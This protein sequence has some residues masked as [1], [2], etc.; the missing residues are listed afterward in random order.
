MYK[1]GQ[2]ESRIAFHPGHRFFVMLLTAT[3]VLAIW[4]PAAAGLF[5]DPTS[6]KPNTNKPKAPLPPLD[7]KPLMPSDT[8]DTPSTRSS[9]PKSQPK[10]KPVE[11]AKLPIPT[12]SAR[13]AAEKQVKD[14]MGDEIAKARTP[15]DK[16]KLAVQMLQTADGT[17][18]AASKY[19]LLRDG[20]GL[21]ADAGDVETAMAA[22]SA[23][24]RDFEPDYSSGAVDPLD[25]FSRSSVDAQGQGKLCELALRGLGNAIAANRFD[26]ARQFG[27]LAVG[28]AHKSNDRNLSDRAGSMMA[29]ITACESEYARVAPFEATLKKTP[30]D[31]SAN[32]A[33]GRF[34]CFVKGNWAVGL[35]ML[36]K[37]SNETLK[38]AAV[39]E[40][41]PPATSQEQL[42][43]ADA[44]WGMTDGLPAAIQ[45]TVRTHAAQWYSQASDGLSGLPK[46]KAEQ[47]VAQMQPNASKPE[48][49]TAQNPKSSKP[50]KP[51]KPAPADDGSSG[52][53][54]TVEVNGPR[55]VI[56]AVPPDMFPKSL[57]EWTD[58]RQGAVNEILD[59]KLN[60]QKGTFNLVVQEVYPGTGR[61]TSRSVLV[62]KISFR[63][64]LRFDTDARNQLNGLRVGGPC[65]VTGNIYFPRFEG[66]ELVVYM[67][68]C[69]RLR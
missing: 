44:W 11:P 69:T 14:V 10:P 34:E 3:L 54:T 12:D 15:A 49:A 52:S 6:S 68:H 39:N 67:Q 64:S 19:V 57:T 27:K 37:G 30:A 36:I 53:T 17:A 58:E 24:M 2:R 13:K 22:D 56:A 63:L 60:G 47:R 29:S 55:D 23:V 28:F 51:P 26:A 48:V 16:T 45:T 66:M 41:K 43:V 62:G 7:D 21:A 59:Q 65:T 31:P 33:I 42:A 20:E 40:L 5:D 1:L 35:P 50:G 38:Q 18:E 46:L 9:N 8:G 4:R 32:A 61:V 25:K